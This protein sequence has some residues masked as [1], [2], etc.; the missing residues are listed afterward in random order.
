MRS[1]RPEFSQSTLR[2]C[3][4]S[5]AISAAFIVATVGFG[6]VLSGCG[7]ETNKGGGVCASFTYSEWGTCVGGTRTRTVLT[8]SPT[9]CTGGTPLV[10]ESCRQANEGDAPGGGGTDYHV[11]EGEAYKTLGAVPWYRLQPGDTVYVHPGTYHERIL[12]SASG[13]ESQWIRVRGIPDANGNLPIISGA[14][15][16]TSTNNHW[17]WENPADLQVFA[18][19]AVAI[20]DDTE[21]PPHYVEIANLQI[22]DATPSN[23]FTAENGRTASYAELAAC[24]YAK[25]PVH[26]LV[27]DNILTNCGWGFFDWTGPGVPRDEF[28]SELAAD[29]VLRNNYLYNNGPTHQ[30]YTEADGVIIE[31][32]RFGPGRAGSYGNHIKDR[33]AGTVIRY[34]YFEEAPESGYTIDLPEPEEGCPSLCYSFG[35][36]TYPNPKY[37]QTFIYGNVFIRSNK[38]ANFIHWNEDHY[39]GRGRALEPNGRLYFYHN[40]IVDTSGLDFLFIEQEGGYDC[41]DT[42]LPG[43]VDFRNNLLYSTASDYKIGEYCYGRPAARYVHGNWDFGVNWISPTWSFTGSSSTGSASVISPAVND[44]G[45]LDLAGKDFRLAE[46][47][48]SGG[49]GGA[50]APAV[51]SNNLG[52][53]LT[54]TKQYVLPDATLTPKMVP[55]AHSGTGS[56][57]GAFER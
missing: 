27:R 18:L 21:T 22:Q 41:P 54:P 29:I 7:A 26:L 37:L 9:G 32:N 6:M 47:S 35:N 2:Y 17:R 4:T 10:A 16:T 49:I 53:D 30:V 11:G 39:A 38:N 8:S 45:F 13:T 48:S 34:N 20:S 24:I 33:S 28:G 12:I 56:D 31:G 1:E 42:D 14:N 44:P 55:R 57:L 5:R 50:L 40:T 25:S 23:S 3:R 46:G 36:P 51:T 15:A 19:V 52:I 43:R